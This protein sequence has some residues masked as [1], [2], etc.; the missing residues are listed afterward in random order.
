MGFE[1]TDSGLGLLMKIGVAVA[2][3]IENTGG[4]N[5]AWSSLV[6]PFALTD[7]MT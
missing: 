1:Q 6:S 5:A 4:R 7:W 2:R 3:Q